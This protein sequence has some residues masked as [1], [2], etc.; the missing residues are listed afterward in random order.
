MGC[1]EIIMS[2]YRNTNVNRNVLCGE[3]W[4]KLIESNSSY[5]YR[6]FCGP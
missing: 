3:Q 6:S 2:A 4:Y 5:S 1:V